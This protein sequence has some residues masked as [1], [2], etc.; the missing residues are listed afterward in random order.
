M[1]SRFWPIAVVIC[2][3]SLLT[4]GLFFYGEA[5]SFVIVEKVLDWPEKVA[6]DVGL[7]LQAKA[8]IV[9]NSISLPPEDI[10]E[11]NLIQRKIRCVTK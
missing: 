9:N 11:L 3:L 4:A 7:L 1:K 8:T 6:R 5:R 2:F 10:L